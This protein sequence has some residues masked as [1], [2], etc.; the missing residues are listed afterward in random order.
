MIRAHVPQKEVAG[1]CPRKILQSCWNSRMVGV[2]RKPQ[3]LAVLTPR[4]I[5]CTI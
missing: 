5:V 3:Y 4:F 2:N 1:R